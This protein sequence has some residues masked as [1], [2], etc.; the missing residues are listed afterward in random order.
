MSAKKAWILYTVLR[1]LFF[2]VPFTLIMLWLPNVYANGLTIGVFFAVI[3]AAMISLALSLLF[4]GKL[5]ERAAQGVA[6]WRTS[7]HT[8]D[9][10]VEDAAIDE[11]EPET[12]RN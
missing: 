7:S 3:C 9:S 11:L 2:A 10:D 8:H 5:R 1:L 12:P 4:L 6:E